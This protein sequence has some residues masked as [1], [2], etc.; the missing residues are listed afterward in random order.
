MT[1]NVELLN[2]VM[3]RIENAPEGEW[4]QSN[5]CKCFAGQT[6]QELGYETT[7]GY[8]REGYLD[9]LG[10]KGAES[11][12]IVRIAWDALGLSQAERYALFDGTN[13]KEHLRAIVSSI[14]QRVLA[15][16]MEVADEEPMIVDKV[17]ESV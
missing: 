2:R 3:D 4:D 5:W 17:L 6:A 8:N 7:W 1:A 14:T 12:P 10:L 15:E 9:A 11:K 16:E 13:T